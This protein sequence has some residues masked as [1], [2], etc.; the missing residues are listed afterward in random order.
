MFVRALLGQSL[1]A[2]GILCRGSGYRSPKDFHASEAAL[3][4]DEAAPRRP[5]PF[6]SSLGVQSDG[7]TPLPGI[8]VHLP[9]VSASENTF[10]RCV[11]APADFA[12]IWSPKAILNRRLWVITM[13]QE[14][15]H[16]YCSPFIRSGAHGCLIVRQSACHQAHQRK[17]RIGS[18]EYTLAG[19]IN[20]WENRIGSLYKPDSRTAQMFCKAFQDLQ[21]LGS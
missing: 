11:T 19:D 20:S 6:K 21:R 10:A 9:F 7:G 18:R 5:K 1:A 3:W 16:E 4:F 8:R 13:E 17:E 12:L 2:K 15:S 14:P